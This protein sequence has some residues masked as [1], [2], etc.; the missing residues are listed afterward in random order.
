[1]QRDDDAAA[2]PRQMLAVVV[3]SGRLELGLVA[4]GVELN[5]VPHADDR[6]D[7]ADAELRARMLGVRHSFGR[8][9]RDRVMSRHVR[10]EPLERFDGP[11]VGRQELA[12]PLST[13][14][15]AKIS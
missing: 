6:L 10:K 13:S 14:P 4:S 2:A 12:S 15:S 9:S 8:Q 5:R 1:M 3:E 11:S 7:A